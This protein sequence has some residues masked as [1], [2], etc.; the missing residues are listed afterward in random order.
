[1]HN[2]LINKDM[3]TFQCT[4]V[5]KG[6]SLPSSH[7]AQGCNWSSWVIGA[8]DVKRHML[9]IKGK[10]TALANTRLSSRHKEHENDESCT[11][12]CAII[13]TTLHHHQCSF[14]CTENGS[15]HQ[16]LGGCQAS[17]P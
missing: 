7:V 6:S 1:M 4:L 8:S 14:W 11:T 2:F 17:V 10:E 5:L 16:I 3:P 12:G 15:A 9:G 13:I